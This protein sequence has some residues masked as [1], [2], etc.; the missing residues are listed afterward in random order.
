MIVCVTFSMQFNLFSGVE[1]VFRENMAVTVGG[2]LLVNNPTVGADVDPIY[3]TNCFFQYEVE[4]DGSKTLPPKS[5][6][7]C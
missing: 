4:T 3:N 7:Q 6:V 1:V 2:A 5:W